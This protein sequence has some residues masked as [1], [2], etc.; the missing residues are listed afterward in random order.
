MVVGG[1]DVNMQ[2]RLRDE[3]IYNLKQEIA[4]LKEEKDSTIFELKSENEQLRS[5]LSPALIEEEGVVHLHS[6]LFTCDLHGV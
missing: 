6:L 3:I 5:K 4:S 2:L 1:G